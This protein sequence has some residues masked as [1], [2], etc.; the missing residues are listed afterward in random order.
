MDSS[1]DFSSEKILRTTVTK[2]DEQNINQTNTTVNIAE[3]KKKRQ[4]KIEEFPCDFCEAKIV[5]EL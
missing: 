4:E 3:P 2:K 1:T 5:R